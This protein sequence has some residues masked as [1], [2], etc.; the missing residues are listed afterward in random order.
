MTTE[1]LAVTQKSQWTDNKNLTCPCIFETELKQM[2][3][4]EIQRLLFSYIMCA[5]RNNHGQS[6]ISVK[7]MFSFL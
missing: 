6:E 1:T 4:S 7:I 3:F 5:N 2:T